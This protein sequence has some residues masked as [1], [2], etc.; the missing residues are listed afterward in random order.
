MVDANPDNRG[1][2]SRRPGRDVRSWVSPDGKRELMVIGDTGWIRYSDQTPDPRG[3]VAVENV[4]DEASAQLL[5]L[6]VIKGLGLS[7]NDF[8]KKPGTTNQ[9]FISTVGRVRKF[10]PRTSENMEF[11]NRHTIHLP[12]ALDGI[13]FSGLGT[14]GGLSVSFGANGKIVGLELVWPEVERVRPVSIPDQGNLSRQAVL[15]KFRSDRAIRKPLPLMILFPAVAFYYQGND[16]TRGNGE[17]IPY[18]TIGVDY[19]YSTTTNSF[20]ISGPVEK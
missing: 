7:L 18:V 1:S 11:T 17:V 13:P 3:M 9:G 10:N 20:T 16:P 2:A 5:A 12:R 6:K 15:G 19:C 4:P 14:H 8:A